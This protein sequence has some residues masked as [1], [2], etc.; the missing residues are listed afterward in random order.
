M[1]GIRWV[2]GFAAL[3]LGPV[4]MVMRRLYCRGLSRSTARY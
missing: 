2:A 4:E 3:F 1:G